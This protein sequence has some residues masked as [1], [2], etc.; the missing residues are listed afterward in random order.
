MATLTSYTHFTV[1]VDDGVA[2]VLM[3]KQGEALN[4][5]DPSLFEDVTGIID[6][7]END[8]AVRAVVLASR[9][10]EGF[11][12]GANI[13]WFET[14]RSADEATSLLREG[15]A[16]FNRIEELHTKH[17][18]PVVA[19]IH[20]PALGG[21]LEY[22]LTASARIV[23]D[24]PKTQLGQP[25]VQLGILPAVG[26]TQRLPGLIGIANALD[27][28]L[29]GRPIDARKARRLGL[30]DEVVPEQML[31]DIAIQR[32]R[33]AA[34]A[35]DDGSGNG[36]KLSVDAIQKLALERNRL[37]REIL[38]RQARQRVAKETRGNYPA[39]PRIIEAVEI[40]IDE[41]MAAGLEAEARFLGELIMTPESRALR[42]IF[43]ASRELKNERWVEAQ[44]LPV[45]HLAVIGGG[46]M[47]GG[48]AAVSAARAGVEVRVK[49]VD[50]A[51]VGRALKHVHDYV[52]GR[53]KRRRMR[54]FEAQQV[55][56][57]VTGSVDWSGFS[58]SDLVV[59]AVFE[60]LD[61]KRSI[62]QQVEGLTRPDTVFASNTS[63]L[64]IGD[65]AAASARPETVIGMHYFSP[66]EKMPLLEVVVTE[67]TGD[68]A[69]ATA[70][71]FGRRQGKTVI[72]V[73]DGTGFYTSR[74]L[75]PYGREAFFLLE[76]GASVEAIDEAIIDWGFPVGPLL[77]SDEVG[78]DTQAHIGQI[79]VDAFGERMLGPDLPGRLVAD[80][81]KGRKNGRG[82]Y[83]YDE[84]G[85]RGGVDESVYAALGLGPRRELPETE[86]QQRISLALINEAALCLQE[87]ILRS[88][89]DG[90]IGA[91]MGIGFPPFRGGPFWYVDQVGVDEIVVQLRM[92]ESR[93]G[94][95]FAP[96][97]IL[98]DL[99]AQDGTFRG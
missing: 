94:P 53:V 57:R 95:R 24:S 3:D 12:A 9:K 21:G 32:A 82:W 86:I 15:Q 7:L 16:V 90:D 80:G 27:L 40:G 62:L 72:V 61:L 60:D 79:M 85:K 46:L 49:E 75:G 47:G 5:L 68:W 73:N 83:Q 8:H 34:G 26:G 4:T 50:N 55:M 36:F 2:L 43:F 54:D 42:S 96:A 13:R 30:V 74:I 38:F 76:E 92:L 10:P 77:L 67:Q 81:R 66:V 18:K 56:L 99:A 35:D 11:L 70:V 78:I 52:R 14:L 19:A 39:P 23:T 41:G 98:V 6:Q 29:T 91:V 45:E 93:H 63:S 89:R 64:P 1:T 87:G 33:E 31:L 97:Q 84:N 20:G 59:E 22:A 65:I 51:G 69:T 48:I 25:E 88:A 44:P 17:G 58:N 28:M 37:G 71:E